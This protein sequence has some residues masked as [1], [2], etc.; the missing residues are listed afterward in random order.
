MQSRRND[1]DVTNRVQTTDVIS[2]HREVARLF[3]LLYPGAAH[4]VMDRAFND[5]AKV[6]A[7]QYP[8]LQACD[9]AYHNLQH[10]LDVTLAMTRLMDGY[11]RSR[12]GTPALGVR[13]FQFGV[14]IAAESGQ[15]E[16]DER[17]FQQI[18]VPL[19]GADIAP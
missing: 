10:V 4:V 18:D 1:Y 3:R 12:S 5:V 13:F 8:G 19:H 11:E 9:T 7:G 6:Y 16:H 15:P 14:Q 2:V 17:F